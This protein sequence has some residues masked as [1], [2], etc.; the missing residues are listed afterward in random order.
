MIKLSK[1]NYYQ[2]PTNDDKYFYYNSNSNL[3]IYA[4]NLEYDNTIVEN[5]EHT[6]LTNY[7]SG[8]INN[9]PIGYYNMLL[10][11][12]KTKRPTIYDTRDIP[13]VVAGTPDYFKRL[14]TSALPP[15]LYVVLDDF[16]KYAQIE[17]IRKIYK[18]IKQPNNNIYK[19]IKELFDS[20]TVVGLQNNDEFIFNKLCKIVEE[21]LKDNTELY[22]NT[23]ITD[24]LKK[25]TQLNQSILLTPS[26]I[27]Y[28]FKYVPKEVSLTTT[29]I[30]FDDTSDIDKDD[31][32]NLYPI[33]KNKSK[34]T[35]DEF[36]IYPNDFS[37]N[38][39]LKSK[40]IIRINRNIIDKIFQETDA[41]MINNYEELSS[42]YSIVKYYN[43]KVLRKINSINGNLVGIYPLDLKD[44]IK[45]EYDNNIAKININPNILLSDILS[46]IDGNLYKELE[47]L[48]Q[49]NES[50]GNN[51][52]EHMENSFHL[53]SYLTL[54]YLS[55]ELVNYTHLYT[56]VYN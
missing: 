50:Y 25:M 33:M 54:Q 16:Y 36:I 1:F 43:Y 41:H 12:Y 15:S 32:V 13:D 24:N 19:K 3:S 27:D 18:R 4:D 8:Y 53:S 35:D 2:I 20:K 23:A 39:L 21:I 6:L 29:N 42:L 10:K 56:N 30:N 44:F 17:T 28:V 37:N 46:N 14:K 34:N 9:S 5:N 55:E 47:Q 38:S 49:S 48:I 52:M 7:L 40:T 11:E 22:I 26:A 51:I 45:N 31:F